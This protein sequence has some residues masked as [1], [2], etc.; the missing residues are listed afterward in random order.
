MATRKRT[1]V[2]N[3]PQSRTASLLVLGGARS[4]K[5]GFAQGLAE[6]SG[7]DAIFIATAQ[8]YDREMEERIARHARARDARWRLV[9]APFDLTDAIAAHADVGRI[10]LVDC[11]TLWLSNIMLR[12]DDVDRATGILVSAVSVLGGPVILVS[13]EVGSGIVP[14]T[15]LGR[16]F[17]DEQGRLNQALARTC[18]GV[19]LVAAGLPLRLKPAPTPTFCF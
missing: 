11:L 7:L 17:R 15:V 10:L 14:D 4:G 1:I 19:V 6:D 2:V 12:G 9:E 8:A 13:N 18:S 16:R 3:E 5:S